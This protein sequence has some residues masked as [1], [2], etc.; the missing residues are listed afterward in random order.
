MYICFTFG[1]QILFS[2]W[3]DLDPPG[4][5]PNFDVDYSFCV[6]NEDEIVW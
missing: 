5:L 6:I 3:T 4:C 1:L 2:V